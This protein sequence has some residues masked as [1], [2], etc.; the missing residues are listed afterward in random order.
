[1]EDLQVGKL[2][3]DSRENKKLLKYLEHF[4]IEYE[5]KTLEV[6]DF[7]YPEKDVCIERKSITDFVGSYISGHIQKQLKNM[8]LNF[9]R[10]YVFISGRYNY[11]AFKKHFRYISEKSIEKMK[12]HLLLDFPKLR[13]IEF[14][15]DKHLVRGVKEI[16]AY[17]QKKLD[18][19]K[20]IVK[21]SKDL[22]DVYFNIL[23]CVPE[24]SSVRA[25]AI[26]KRHP[27]I[28]NLIASLSSGEFS[29]KGIYKNQ[30]AWL[31]KVF[32]K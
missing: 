30:K 23:C 24:I 14:L 22:N 9:D 17:E 15:N 8:D 2:Y 11:F 28:K 26:V 12:I 21:K 18:F 5:V 10:Y 6:G 3:V 29:V 13:I 4:D 31:E 16:I 7:Y 1:M 25:K 27:T 20:Q 32:L 19:K